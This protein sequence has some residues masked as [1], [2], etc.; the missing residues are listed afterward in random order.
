MLCKLCLDKIYIKLRKKNNGIGLPEHRLP[1]AILGGLT[2]VP[3]LALYGWCAEYR[4]SLALF[5]ISVICTRFSLLLVII[6]LMAY[7]VDAS[8][9]YSA[10]AL[11]GIIVFRCLAGAFMPLSTPPIIRDLGYGWGFSALAC[12]ILVLCLV[13]ILVQSYGP[14]WRLRSKYTRDC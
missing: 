10:S 11:T 7:V 9:F 8:G 2:L 12:A 1:M 13:P 5:I 6:P 14:R 3:A 4:M